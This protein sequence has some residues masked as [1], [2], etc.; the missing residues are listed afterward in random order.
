M[1]TTLTDDLLELTADAKGWG[2][3]AFAITT[4]CCSCCCSSS[5]PWQPL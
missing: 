2:R 1:F 4:A 5:K 3:P